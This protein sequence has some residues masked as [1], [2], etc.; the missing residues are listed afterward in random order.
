MENMGL[1]G[2][3]GERAAWEPVAGG[4]AGGERWRWWSVSAEGE[5]V[6]AGGREPG[7]GWTSGIGPRKVVS[8]LPL[9]GCQMSSLGDSLPNPQKWSIWERSDSFGAMVDY[10][11]RPSKA[12]FRVGQ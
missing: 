8:E 12:N 1:N 7:G 6:A 9:L 5:A 3:L 2:S 11:S 10:F 4:G